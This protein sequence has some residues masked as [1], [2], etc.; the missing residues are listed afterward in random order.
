LDE[1]LRAGCKLALISAPA[2]FGKTTLLSQCIAHWDRRES[3]VRVAWLSADQGDNDPIRFWRYVVVALQTIDPRLGEAAQ[4]TL[5][6]AQP[7]P[8]EDLLIGLI[9]EIAA[10]GVQRFVLVLDDFHLID[11]AQIYNGLVF[12]LDNLPPPPGGMHLII[13][14][15]E[16]LPWPI[17][18]SR[19]RGELTELRSVDLRF[20]L[21]EVTA[22]LNDAVG[23]GLSPENVTALDAR[24]EGWIAGLQMAA[25]S[26]RERKQSQGAHGLSAFIQTLSASHRFIL[27]YLVEEV[28]D[29][30]PP[31]IQAFLLQT[32]ILEQMT[33]SLCDAVTGEE[34]S[35]AVLDQLEQANLFLIPLDDERRWYRYHHLFADLLRMRQE[36]TG[37]PDVAVLHRRASE[38]YEQ[39]GLIGA[40]VGHALGAGDVER[41]ARL[42]RRNA[43][44]VMDYDELATV[45][46]WLD[47]LSAEFLRTRPWLGIACAWAQFYMGRLDVVQLQLH[48]VESGLQGADDAQGLAGHIAAIR[49]YIAAVSGEMSQ[50]KLIADQALKLLPERDQ[51][52]RGFVIAL[53]STILRWS[54]DL[55]AAAEASAQAVSISRAAQDGRVAVEA[56]IIHGALRHWQGQ[57]HE[58]F[59]VCEEALLLADQCARQQGR[60]P[61][62]A[63]S[64]HR[65][66]SRILYEWNDLEGALRHARQGIEL[67]EEWGGVED[68]AFA[69][70]GLARVLQ[71]TGDTQ[72]ALDAIQKGRQKARVFSSWF[73]N[74]GA[75]HQARLWLAQDNPPAA[76]RWAQE[77]GL[78]ADDEPEFQYTWEYSVLARVLIAQ[79]TP[80]RALAL[81]KKLL[82]VSEAAGAGLQVIETL[83]LQALALHMRGDKEQAL[84]VLARAL[85][86][87][88]PE[89]LV[90]TFIDEGPP[91]GEL[92]REAA[93]TGTV[94]EYALGLL[95]AL[96][97]ETERRGPGMREMISVPTQMPR[98]EPGLGSLVEPLT[99]REV[100]VLRLLSTHL[101]APEVAEELVIS[102]HTVRTHIKRIYGKLGVHSRAD[103]IRRARELALL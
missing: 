72:G 56:L 3:G 101:S 48:N 68:M 88:E 64:V 84:T 78:R 99:D 61:P 97:L 16:D 85:Y 17:A 33:A 70:I 98:K 73:E 23:L 2:G 34:E 44:A 83:I 103:A 79:G 42:A 29:Q 15:R 74:Y 1:G 4:A 5:Q 38:W 20:T 50:A 32:S 82:S 9:N 96:D 40:A 63:A 65:L 19:A 57:I 77:S 30:Q 27:D 11:E 51:A 102:R 100:E 43:L 52:M 75:A 93:R 41:V 24:T 28:L 25:I 62:V 58:A 13:S 46:R 31:V 36:E 39:N 66:V 86:L 21:D 12:L 81:L 37:R 94:V 14:S 10:V 8:T 76:M 69:Y 45:V 67:S 47:T 90:R 35:Q 55:V 54:G 53:Q 7:L 92:L 22:F 89:G 60:P 49:C 59:A 71:A 80:D 26:M 95:T 91:M 87:A 18:R 6:T